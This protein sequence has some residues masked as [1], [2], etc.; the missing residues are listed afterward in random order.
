MKNK[1]VHDI[2]IMVFYYLVI[3]WQRF[4]LYLFFNLYREFKKIDY[5]CAK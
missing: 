2:N 1:M 5:F 3:T 4:F